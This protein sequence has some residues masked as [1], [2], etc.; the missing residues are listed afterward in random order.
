MADR[1]TGIGRYTHELTYALRRLDP[2]LDIILLNPYPGSR[3][4]WY[5]DFPTYPVPSLKLLPG[6]VGWG[7]AVLARAARA[8]H[9]DVLHDPC[10]IAPFLAPRLGVFRVV[11]VHDA[12]PYVYPEAHQFLTRFVFRTLVPAARWTADA[13]LTDSRSARRDLIRH[14]GFRPDRV[15]VTRLGV[16]LPSPSQIEACRR[17]VTEVTERYGITTPYFLYVGALNPRKNVPRLLAAFEEVRARHSQVKLV[18][19]GPE[20]WAADE[21]L[22]RCRHMGDAVRLTGFVSDQTVHI[23]Y[24]GAAALVFP[25]LYEGFG[26]PPLEALAHGTP[27]ITSNTSSLPEVVGEAG[28]L[29]DPYDVH[30]IARAMEQLLVDEKLAG[31]LRR[32]GRERA[33]EF[34]WE[35]TARETLHIYQRG[36]EMSGR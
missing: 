1:L 25:S 26:L 24:A 22:A 28:V 34:S 6:V 29:V 12:I 13:I 32:A 30:A 18:I 7:S 20:T 10:G 5:R 2:A 11:T 33:L 31:S 8:L 19:V 4:P 36:M 23:L 35:C 9:L 15:H 16:N 21:T 27:V 3:L 14:V 17:A